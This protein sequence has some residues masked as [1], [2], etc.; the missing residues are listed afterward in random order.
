MLRFGAN[1]MVN[2]DNIADDVMDRSDN[3]GISSAADAMQIGK[4]TN[5]WG[6]CVLSVFGG[7]LIAGVVAGFL[8]DGGDSGGDVCG[9][10]M[11]FAP[12]DFSCAS[13]FGKHEPFEVA[14]QVPIILEGPAFAFGHPFSLE[15]ATGLT[16]NGQ[17]V[18]PNV[19]SERG[20]DGSCASAE[21]SAGAGNFKTCACGDSIQASSPSG[22]GV[23]S[24][25]VILKG[26]DWVDVDVPCQ[27]P[28]APSPQR[29]SCG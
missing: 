28:K 13:P 22:A 5:W 3:S 23:P 10:G 7:N 17:V 26:S 18:K 15:Q 27:I 21:L 8:L 1:V 12:A 29:W 2:L 4:F 14:P 16:D 19:S 25:R 20:E 6:V 24:Q 11:S 9:F